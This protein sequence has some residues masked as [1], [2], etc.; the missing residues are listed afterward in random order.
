MSQSNCCNGVVLP[1]VNITVSGQ[2]SSCVPTMPR[3]LDGEGLFV[4]SFIF[5]AVAE[6][7]VFSGTDRYGK[8]FSPVVGQTMIIVNGVILDP[9]D[10]VLTA[11]QLTLNVP[12]KYDGDNIAAIVFREPDN[13]G[14][15]DLVSRVEALEAIHEGELSE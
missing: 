2:G 11:S 7:S 14:F 5:D 9:T 8:D 15:Q 6:Q 10:Y 12:C 4:S 1:G 3:D 13:K